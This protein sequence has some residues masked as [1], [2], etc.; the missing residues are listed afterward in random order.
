MTIAARSG[1]V[2]DDKPP[3]FTTYSL[4]LLLIPQQINSL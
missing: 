4:Y 2:I 1:A 3:T